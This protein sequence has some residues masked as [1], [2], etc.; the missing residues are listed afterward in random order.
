MTGICNNCG[1]LLPEGHPIGD[2]CEKCPPHLCPDCGQMDSM[3]TPCP[4]WVSVADI[5][6]A[7]L[8]GMFAQ[9][10]IGLELNG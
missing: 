7:D 10:G 2:Y 6:F 8:K 3:E 9:D 1:Q 5:P 4:C